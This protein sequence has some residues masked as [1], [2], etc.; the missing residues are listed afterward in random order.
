LP[1]DKENISFFDDLPSQPTGP[2]GFSYQ[3]MVRCD[4]CLRANPPT[5]VN[6]LY[7]GLAL[8]V[9]EASVALAKPSLRPLES[10]EQGYNSIL[11]R[12]RAG[13]PSEE[14]L[15]QVAALLRLE[16]SAV[17]RVLSAKSALPVARTSTPEEAALVERRLNELGL[18]TITVP[19]QELQID[20]SPPRRLRR[21]ELREADFLAYQTLSTEGTPIDWGEISLLVVGRLFV[22]QVELSEKKRRKAENEILD[23]SEATSDEAVVD[24]YAG[25]QPESWRISSS[26]FD[27][28]CLGQNKALLAGENFPR[29]INLI[30]D[31]APN[32]EFNDSYQL[33]RHCLEMVWPA[34]KRVESGGLKLRGSKY[35][36]AEI[37]TTSSEPQ[38]TRYSRLCDYLKRSSLVQP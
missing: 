4:E 38:F 32:A 35:G 3:Q 15:S 20:T 27:F 24:I 12:L 22:K 33:V 28:S 31:Y 11:L 26:A 25:K 19:D 9:T 21:L 8:P 34:Q 2:A 7:C 18:E 5:R 10:W 6:C 1:N 13:E 36:T 17:Q 29:L 16:P 23:S 30:R 14:L 37:I